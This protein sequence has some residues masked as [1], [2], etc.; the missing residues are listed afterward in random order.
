MNKIAIVLV[1]LSTL[2]YI[3]NATLSLACFSI[4]FASLPS[5]SLNGN[6]P[7]LNTSTFSLGSNVGG[8]S[9]SV[10]DICGWGVISYVLLHIL[11]SLLLTQV[12]SKSAKARI[13]HEAKPN[14][15]TDAK[16]SELT[17][18]LQNNEQYFVSGLKV[19][20]SLEGNKLQVSPVLATY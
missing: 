14:L 2:P 7:I 17:A 20:P 18:N 11:P 13:S 12:K 10:F 4:P 1:T 5:I 19:A 16:Q 3:A 6:N 9:T 8:A 15:L